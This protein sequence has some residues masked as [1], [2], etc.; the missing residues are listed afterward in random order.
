M[1]GAAITFADEA[2]R[3][4]A[5]WRKPPIPDGE[6]GR[7]ARGA[8]GRGVRL[9]V[10]QP[11]GVQGTGRAGH[12]VRADRRVLPREPA[13]L[14]EPPHGGVGPPVPADE[15]HERAGRRRV[16]VQHAWNRDTLPRGD[17]AVHPAVPRPSPERVGGADRRREPRPGAAVRPRAVRRRAPVSRGARCRIVWPHRWEHDKDPEAFFAAVTALAHEGLDFEVAVAGQEF[18][19][20]GAGSRPPP[21]RWATGSRTSASPRGATRT[22]GCWRARTSPCRPPSTSSSA[23][24]WSR[25]PTRGCFPLVPDR[26]AYPGDL[27]ARDALRRRRRSSSRG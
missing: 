14:P 21:R 18:A 25:R 4:D 20:T 13:R 19:E 26:L 1:R 8:L 15:R 11:R 12:R 5:E 22:R 6:P 24:R 27:P 3:L 23:W 2:R 10:P 7:R 16:L 9:D 17:R